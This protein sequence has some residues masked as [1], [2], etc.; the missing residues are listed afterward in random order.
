M[1]IKDIHDDE[2]M[3]GGGKIQYPN[4]YKHHVDPTF[5]VSPDQKPI[6]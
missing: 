1:K 4:Q 6:S 5:P 3:F 2:N